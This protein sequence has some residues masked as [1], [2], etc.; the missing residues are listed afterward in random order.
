[1]KKPAKKVLQKRPGRPATGQ[2]PVTAIRL[3][4]ELRGAVV[5][6]AEKQPGTPKFSEAIRRLVELGLTVKQLRKPTPKASARAAELAA[7]VID[8]RADTAASPT[9]RDERKRRLLKGPLVF[10]EMRRD[11][12]KN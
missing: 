5:K 3:P 1:M 8:S 12:Q 7:K 4:A 9:E 2:D 10:R 11:R 6:W